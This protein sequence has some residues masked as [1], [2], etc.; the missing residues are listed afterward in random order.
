MRRLLT[1]GM[2]S[3]FGSQV[4]NAARSFHDLHI[5]E[6]PG[7]VTALGG[8]EAIAARNPDVLL[9]GPELDQAV[10]LETA[11]KLARVAPAVTVVLATRPDDDTWRRALE[12]GVRAVVDPDAP[13]DE[14]HQALESALDNSQR[15][16]S[17]AAGRSYAHRVIVISSPK[18]GV[19]KTVVAVNLALALAHGTQEK[20]AIV[21]LDLAFGDVAHVLMLTPEHTITDA[22]AAMPDLDITALK[23]FLTAHPANVFA[24]CSPDDPTEAD[25]ISPEAATAII[26]LLTT[27]FP[28]VIVDTAGGFGDHTYSVME[29]ASDLVFVSDM[30]VPSIINVRKALELIDRLGI[31]DH[32]RH[33]VLNRADSRVG[34]Q[35]DEVT[36]AAGVPVDLALPSSRHI[37]ISVNEG[38][39]ILLSRPRSQFARRI[40]RLAAELQIAAPALTTGEA[41]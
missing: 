22:A 11:A 15:I 19:G 7:A 32:N 12:A 3:E 28:Y 17:L 24:L 38:R 14:V 23:V 16:R 31:V 4:E 29:H 20:V 10:A 25:D 8:V 21:D 34:L 13:L 37:P 5:Q 27:E 35:L 9:L 33:L 2:G 36:A 39:P 30:D 40:T 41:P 26:D 1:T 18:G 6:W